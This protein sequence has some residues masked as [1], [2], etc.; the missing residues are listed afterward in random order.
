MNYKD[1]TTTRVG[2]IEAYIGPMNIIYNIT[3][4]VKETTQEGSNTTARES[5][6]TGSSLLVNDS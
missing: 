5:I 3:S 6:V 4:M 2:E 1:D